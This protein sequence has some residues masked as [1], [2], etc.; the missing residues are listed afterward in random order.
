MTV[1]PILYSFRRCPY[2][3]RARLAVLVSGVECTIREVNLADKPEPLILA[4]PKA[5]I[6]VMVLGD[7]RVLEESLDIMLYVLGI[8][9]PENW[10]DDASDQALAIIATN[11][12]AFKSHLD[13]YKYPDR[14]DDD[15]FVHRDGAI[16]IL[17]GLDALLTQQPFL[18]RGHCTYVDWA[19]FPFI[20][21]FAAIDP[22]WFAAQNL[23]YL[24]AWLDGLLASN[25]FAKAMVTLPV[26]TVG[27]APTYF[28]QS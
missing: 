15:P 5:T 16:A 17:T 11:D 3:I 9:D 8:N 7:D 26:W 10:L 18:D 19:V 4:S 21:Q 22:T 24:N 28:P 27:D 13:H 20:R 14:H 1:R 2:A 25:L 6:P 23:I 12:G